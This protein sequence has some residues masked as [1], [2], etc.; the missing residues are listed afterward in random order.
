MKTNFYVDAN[1][2]EEHVDFF[3]NEL[4]P[5]IQQ[6]A[7]QLESNS[8]FWGYHDREIIPVKFEQIYRI[9]LIIIESWQS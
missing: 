3:L 5:K 9:T 8:Q 7:N 2:V 6:L 4:T 1:M